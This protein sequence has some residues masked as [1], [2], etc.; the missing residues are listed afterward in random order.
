MLAKRQT[1]VNDGAWGWPLA[2]NTWKLQKKKRKNKTKQTENHRKLI[3]FLVNFFVKSNFMVEMSH[4]E[5]R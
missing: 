3:V 2:C 1:T 4:S 5:N